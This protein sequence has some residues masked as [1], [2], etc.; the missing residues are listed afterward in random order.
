[1]AAGRPAAVSTGLCDRDTP[2]GAAR[3]TGARRNQ[4]GIPPTG[5]DPESLSREVSAQPLPLGGRLAIRA[6]EQHGWPS[7]G[8][9]AVQQTARLRLPF[10]RAWL[11]ALAL[12]V[13]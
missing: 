11:S 6:R 12:T 9:G 2:C 13:I 7:T 5:A 1:R 3:P 10:R 8:A 4:P